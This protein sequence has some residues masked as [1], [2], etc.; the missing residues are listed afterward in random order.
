MR[1]IRL[2]STFLLKTVSL[3]I[4]VGIVWLVWLIFS[5]FISVLV[6]LVAVA[7]VYYVT[8]ELELLTWA[9]E[10]LFL[11]RAER[12]L[13]PVSGLFFVDLDEERQ[14]EFD[15]HAYATKDNPTIR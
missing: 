9:I 3:A 15:R 8:L 6:A 14:L 2:R 7:V 5:S 10:M 11:Y 1:R 4:A 12:S 13:G